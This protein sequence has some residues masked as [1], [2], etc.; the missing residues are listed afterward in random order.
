MTTGGKI[1]HQKHVQKIKHR[2]QYLEIDPFAATPPVSFATGVE[3]PV[4][5]VNDMLR[6]DDV[7][8]KKMEVFIQKRLVDQSVSC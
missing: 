7:G 1:L 2:L 8:G 4:E 5:I 3:I 6:V